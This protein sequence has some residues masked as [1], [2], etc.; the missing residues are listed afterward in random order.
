MSRLNEFFNFLEEFIQ[1]KPKQFAG[2]W[3]QLVTDPYYLDPIYAPVFLKEKAI[4]DIDEF[5]TTNSLLKDEKYSNILFGEFKNSLISCKNFLKD[6]LHSVKHVD[7]FVKQ[8]NVL[9]RLREQKLTEILPE[10]QQL[11]V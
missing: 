2:V 7:Q 6:N 8:M 10:F 1:L 4:K 5:L 3:F 9:D 11:G